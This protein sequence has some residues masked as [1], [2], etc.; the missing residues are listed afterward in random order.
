M[1]G[2]S[3]EEVI[4]LADGMR[5][6]SLLATVGRIAAC[7]SHAG[8]YSNLICLSVELETRLKV[9]TLEAPTAS[10]TFTLFPGRC[11][12][13]LAEAWHRRG[14]A[15]RWRP[16][17]QQ[18][19]NGKELKRPN[20]SFQVLPTNYSTKRSGVLQRERP[21]SLSKDVQHPR[22]SALSPLYLLCYISA[23]LYRRAVQFAALGDQK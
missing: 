7:S 11:S 21:E 6:R 16:P 23:S 9:D 8:T 10:V 17:F 3:K 13:S 12:R 2:N 1:A 15:R 18:R 20:K 4:P 19:S 5:R 22:L 14:P